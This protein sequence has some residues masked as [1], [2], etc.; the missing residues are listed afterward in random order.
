MEVRSHINALGL[1]F[2]PMR[3]HNLSAM[4]DDETFTITRAQMLFLF[5]ALE[6]AS[7]FFPEDQSSIHL[8]S[9]LEGLQCGIALSDR[10]GDLSLQ[11]VAERTRQTPCLSPDTRFPASQSQTLSESSHSCCGDDMIGPGAVGVKSTASDLEDRTKRLFGGE[12]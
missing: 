1:S 9:Y 6:A 3:P 7:Q 5:R 2:I 4:G 11:A 8:S 10:C 12:A